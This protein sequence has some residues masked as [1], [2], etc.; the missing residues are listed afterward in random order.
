MQ[1]EGVVFIII[2]L[3]LLFIF[4]WLWCKKVIDC[5]ILLLGLLLLFYVV[6]VV[7]VQLLI[8]GI[9]LFYMV[10]YF[11]WQYVLIVYIIMVLIIVILWVCV[12]NCQ[13]EQKQ[14]LVCELQIECEVSFYQWQF[15]GMVVYEFCILL[16]VIQVVL[17]N[18]CFLV[19]LISQEVC[20]DCI[21]CVVIC[22]VQFIDNCFV[23][24]WF[25]FYDLY[26]ECQQIVLLMVI[27]MVVLV[28]V[29]FY[30]YYLNIC[31]YGVV[32]SLQLQVDV[33]L[34]CIVIVNLLDNVVKYLF[35][36]EIVID[37]YFDVG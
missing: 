37:I 2:I 12:E 18:F 24:V 26:V 6:V 10:I 31:Q 33:G 16:V 28:V 27:N 4:W 34:L 15:M 9:I 7:L 29:I 19:V 3:V 25:V 23:D 20:F 30:D 17:E 32:E 8:Y 35:F 1:I 5:I 13:L 14:C 22:L 11:F 36:G 21:G